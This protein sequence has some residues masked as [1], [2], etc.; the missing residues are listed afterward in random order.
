MYKKILWFLILIIFIVYIIAS[1][2]IIGPVSGTIY[3]AKTGEPIENMKIIHTI[4]SRWAGLIEWN[5]QYKNKEYFSDK[6]GIFNIPKQIKF[7][8]F[9]LSFLRGDQITVNSDNNVMWN[10]YHKINS[11]PG[12]AYNDKY[13]PYAYYFLV[14]NFSGYNKTPLQEYN[15]YISKRNLDIKLIPK[16]KSI[17]ECDSIQ[18]AEYYNNCVA[19]TLFEIAFNT[20]NIN[21][22]DDISS[23]IIKNFCKS[24]VKLGLRD[25]ER[26]NVKKCS[27]AK[28]PEDITE[29]FYDESIKYMESLRSIP[30]YEHS[31][32]LFSGGPNDKYIIRKELQDNQT[33][34]L[35]SDIFRKNTQSSEIMNGYQYI[36]CSSQIPEKISIKNTNID[37]NETIIDVKEDFGNVK[38]TV[39]VFL[40]IDSDTWKIYKVYCP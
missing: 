2:K 16:L 20:N 11:Q 12:Y 32:G 33:A 28:K 5:Y 39:R 4:S 34:F 37:G 1:I 22:C 15:K 19:L 18:E 38:K 30:G 6:N 24:D 17:K 21:L 36:L 7:Y 25:K 9:P 26:D 27:E 8:P 13:Y 10:V 29:C 40:K 31:A 35:N 14:K 3:D 23:E